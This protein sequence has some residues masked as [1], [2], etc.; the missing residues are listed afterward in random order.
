[1]KLR[2]LAAVTWLVSVEMTTNTETS[3]NGARLFLSMQSTDVL[4][5]G[6]TCR[7]R[8]LTSLAKTSLG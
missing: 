4:I 7:E 3:A 5:R 6:V 2:I 8:K 1:M